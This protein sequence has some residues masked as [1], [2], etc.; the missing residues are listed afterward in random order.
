M[1]W[2]S[3]SARALF[4]AVVSISTGCTG[5]L[6]E[7]SVSDGGTGSDATSDA[8]ADRTTGP[9]DDGGSGDDGP[10][11]GDGGDDGA[12]AEGGD[13]GS[14]QD[15]GGCPTGQLACNGTC[16][17]ED[18][19]N[20]GSCGKDCTSLVHVVPGSAT[21]TGGSC[22]YQCAA[23]FGDCS[24]AGSGCTTNVT[25]QGNCGMCGVTCSGNEPVCVTGDAGAASCGTGC[26]P[27][28]PTLCNGSCVD[29]TSDPQNCAL[30][31]DV[32]TTSIANAHATCV[33]SAC[34]F[35]CDATYTSCA[36]G[37][38]NTQ[39]DVAHC[40]S[41]CGACP[42]KTNETVTCSSGSC[43]YACVS[44][45]TS[46]NG[47][48]VDLQTDPSNCGAC[49]HGCLG[50]AC[51]AGLCQPVTIAP[52]LSGKG[53][54]WSLTVD[55]SASGNVYYTAFLSGGASTMFSCPKS[56][57]TTPT[58]L[59]AALNSPDGIAWDSATGEIFVADTY[60]GAVEAWLTSGTKVA[61][62]SQSNP[63]SIAVDV[64]YVYWGTGTSIVRAGKDF[65]A[66]TTIAS[67]LSSGVYT[68][69]SDYASGWVFGGVTG[70]TGSIAAAPISG[71]GASLLA[72]NQVYPQDVATQNGTV[73]WITQGSGGGANA[74]VYACAEGGCSMS[75]TTVVGSLTQG[76]CVFTTSS[77]L[78]YVANGDF[79]RCPIGGACP[80][81]TLL[82]TNIYPLQAGACAQ[83][84]TSFYFL[85]TTN[86]VL[87]LA[88]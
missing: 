36:G 4:V 49:G 11:T 82:A 28:T 1:T 79:Y 8:A 68:L 21:C 57:C 53:T 43:T 54:G 23:G 66:P 73:Y 81:P 44:G 48:C 42:S 14:G 5:L 18:V 71:S 56:G 34:G 47:S 63:T 16:V 64:G 78:Y 60:N 26:S 74:G 31:N 39:T 59:T 41:S 67:G 35:A 80:S 20:C 88:K 77:Y 76:V 58:T 13:A 75:P 65:S 52:Q 32:C 15:S 38:W 40:G 83:D 2:G 70:S 9:T 61:S 46:C 45:T 50:G 85:Q 72:S 62:L 69:T 84:S 87:R 37:C 25:Q 30:C 7:F 29:T 86:A 19:H 10:T 55:G 51:S 6:G 17:T 27:P 22:T 24:D 33:N 12:A 3:K